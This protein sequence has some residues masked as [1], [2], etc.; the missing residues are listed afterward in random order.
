M[1]SPRRATAGGPRNPSRACRRRRSPAEG[2]L[3]LPSSVVHRAPRRP[4]P[5]PATAP[6]DGH[7]SPRPHARA[8]DPVNAAIPILGPGRS[9][10]RRR[11]LP[12]ARR[13]LSRGCML[14]V[15]A[16]G[17]LGR[18]STCVPCDVFRVC[19]PTSQKPATTQ[20]Q[21]R[22]MLRHRYAFH[23]ELAAAPPWRLCPSSAV[24]DA[25]S[26]YARAG[27]RPAPFSNPPAAQSAPPHLRAPT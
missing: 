26:A 1:A 3:N 18:P 6:A 14:D 27:T 5:R 4:H 21:H 17:R 20:R 22:K 13:D 25:R 19:L 10:L 24:H 11:V 2:P 8:H 23:K 12:P 9:L 16:G 15:C 7:P